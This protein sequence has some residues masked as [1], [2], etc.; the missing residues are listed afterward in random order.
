LAGTGFFGQWVFNMAD[1]D[2]STNPYAPPAS[3]VEPVVVADLAEEDAL[4]EDLTRAFYA[5]TYG[6][7]MLPGFAYFVALFL[8]A[9]T[10]SRR[11]DFSPKQHRDFKTTAV[12]FL[13][14]SLCILGAI[15][16]VLLLEMNTIVR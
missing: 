14:V 16:A 15:L 13:L 2:Q 10:Y 11:A 8:L 4:Q 9:K 12:I 3:P 7:I 1:F 6:T 5:V